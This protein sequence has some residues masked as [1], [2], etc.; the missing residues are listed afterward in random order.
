MAEIMRE[1]RV[2]KK[3]Y[4]YKNVNYKHRLEELMQ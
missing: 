3:D 2:G 1:V 4:G